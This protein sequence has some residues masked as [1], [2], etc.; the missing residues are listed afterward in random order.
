[1][2]M[3]DLLE[4]CKDVKMIGISGHTRP[5]GDC[6]GST[7]AL[8]LYLRKALPNAKVDVLLEQ[9]AS[10]FSCIR[11]VES[12]C[13]DF[14]Q[15]ITYDVF[16]ALD[17]SKDRLGGTEKYFDAA[18]KRIN[19]DHHISNSGY[20]D[21]NYIVHNASSTSE[22]VYDLLEEKYLDTEIAKAIYI[23]MIHDTG[24]FQYSNTTPK[25][26][27][28]ASKLISFGFDF[29]KIID[30]TFY[31]KTYIQTQ[32]LGRALLESL[33][34]LDG[35]CVVSYIDK[36]MQEFYQVTTK[37]LDGIV[38]QLRMIKGVDCAVFVYQTE[39]QEYKVSMRSNEKINVSEI[40]TY[41]GGGGHLKAAGCTMQGTFHDVINN[42]SIH[43]EKQLQ[44]S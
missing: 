28:I 18:K 16:F 43:I 24:V 2:T 25:T 5:D 1:M 40:A 38:N 39:A 20:G 41:F 32:I 34:L 21:V 3:F 14:N 22:L 27:A 33:T 9:P 4:E 12:I 29:S 37:D 44:D 8:A 42:L 26:L 17:T 31:E 13:T 36:K 10:I 15:E 19:I 30:E 6:V 7:M 23:G 35:R 11:E